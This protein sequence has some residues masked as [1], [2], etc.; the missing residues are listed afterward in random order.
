MSQ[1]TTVRYTTRDVS[2]ADKNQRLIEAVFAELAE[3]APEGLRYTVCRLD[4]GVS[5][6]HSAVIEGD[7]NPL[8]DLASFTAFSSTVGERA[9]EPPIAV[10]GAV[11]GHYS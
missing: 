7:I 2:V 11:I 9:V 4:D 5:F 8:L 1:A 3:A 10:T 6:V